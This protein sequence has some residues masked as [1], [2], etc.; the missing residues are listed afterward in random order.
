MRLAKV[1]NSST[2]NTVSSK[3]SPEHLLAAANCINQFGLV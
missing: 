3:W 2:V 1:F